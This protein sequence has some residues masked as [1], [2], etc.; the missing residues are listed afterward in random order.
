MQEVLSDS[1]SVVVHLW[2]AGIAQELDEHLTLCALEY[3]GTRFVRTPASR[4][5][6][7]IRQQQYPQGPQ[8]LAVRAG[9][10]LAGVRIGELQLGRVGARRVAGDGHCSDES[11]DFGSDDGDD[12]S[13]S[14]KVCLPLLRNSDIL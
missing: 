11:S 2:E 9:R 8:L 13:P 10:V 6:Q 12:S 1:K 14:I 7:W 3:L 4:C 5:K